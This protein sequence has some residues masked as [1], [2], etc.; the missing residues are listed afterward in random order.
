[1]PTSSNVEKSQIGHIQSIKISNPIS[2]VLLVESCLSPVISS[3]FGF[4]V[5]QTSDQ[6]LGVAGSSRVTLDE[7]CQLSEPQQYCLLFGEW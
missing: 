1:M 5:K 2:G 6:T 4:G 3:K 7:H